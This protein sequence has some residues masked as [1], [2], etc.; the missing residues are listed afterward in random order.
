MGEGGRLR[1]SRSKQ[2]EHGGRAEMQGK[3]QHMVKGNRKMEVSNYANFLKLRNISTCGRNSLYSTVLHYIQNTY[4][5]SNEKR[6][7]LTISF[8]EY[9]VNS[10][11][12]TRKFCHFQKRIPSCT[13]LEKF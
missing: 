1:N 13:H 5:V 8:P 7:N 12:C 2:Q 11:V 9:L 10:K 6:V 3:K 4:K